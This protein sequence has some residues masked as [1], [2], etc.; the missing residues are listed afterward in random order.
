MTTRDQHS[1]AAAL[2]E[3]G[4]Q[5]SH[6][7]GRG[8]EAEGTLAAAVAAYRLLQRP[9][10][11][12]EAA[13][14]RRGLARALWR[15]SM[16]LAVGG[17]ATAAMAPGRE[18][19]A[20]FRKVFDAALNDD[21]ASDELLG[22]LAT[23]MNDLSQAAFRAGLP[24]EHRALMRD[25]VKLCEG[26][27]GPLA[28]QALGTAL[29]NQTHADM[30]RVF[31]GASRPS[32][33]DVSAV[34][35]LADRTVRLRSELSDLARPMTVWE[36]AN[37]RRQRGVVLCLADKG[38]QGIADLLAAWD[39]AGQWIMGASV[40]TLRGEVSAA[41]YWAAARY[42]HVAASIDWPA[43][44]GEM[45]DDDFVVFVGSA[46]KELEQKH[47]SLETRYRF[48]LSAR[49]EVDLDAAVI[50]FF[51]RD[52]K[53]HLTCGIIEIGS[54]SPVTRSWKW[55]WSNDSIPPKM[56]ERALPLK[57]LQRITGKDYFG[58]ADPFPGDDVMAW[59]L[60]AIS[61]RHLSALDCYGAKFDGGRLFVF[62]A[63]VDVRV[64]T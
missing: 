12:P 58:S 2:Y 9:G 33:G 24:D 42:P 16:Q 26:Q 59:G 44:S 25:V 11:D 21:A 20:L 30:H 62:L 57:Q 52:D 6:E 17:R 32:A 50:K 63:Y 45:M 56:Q 36:L 29:F 61:V 10:N 23:A 54:Y 46:V 4:V 39:I 37:A 3:R 38:H 48:D 14:A 60:A 31:G 55:G 5:L 13:T 49:W 43:L 34:I 8:E 18:G 22:E 64:E 40:E 35:D 1:G 19:I 53:L 27:P 41:M 28:R 47:K 7:K 51:D 15:Y